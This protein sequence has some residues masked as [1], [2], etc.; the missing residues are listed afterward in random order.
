MEMER[1]NGRK[2]KRKLGKKRKKEWKGM[3]HA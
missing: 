1:E 2:R 3:E